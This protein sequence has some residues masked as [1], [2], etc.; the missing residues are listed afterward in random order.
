[1]QHRDNPPRDDAPD[2]Q[3]HFI[4]P[5]EFSFDSG[6]SQDQTALR[7]KS[8]NKGGNN[9]S[10]DR[11]SGSQLLQIAIAGGLVTALVGVFWVL[12][13]MVEKPTIAI[14]EPT[15][16]TGESTGAG[17]KIK[18]SPFTDA[19]IAQQRREVQKV[20]QD[21]LQL[22]DE[23][24]ERRIE[25][26]AAEEY[27]AART[28]AEEADQIYR[29]RKFQQALEQYRTTRDEFQALRDSIPERIERHLSEGT[30]ALDRGDAEAAHKAFD[31]VL[32]I[33]ED[34]PRGTEGKK[35][36]EKLPQ[37]WEHFLAGQAAFEEN[38]LDN[39]R[40][41]L[42]AALAIDAETQPAKVLLPKVLAAIIE[43]DYS[44]AMSA[45]YA[46]ISDGDFDTAKRE[47][48]KAKK[49]KPDA[50][51]PQIG[52]TQAENGIVQARIDGLFSGASEFERKEQWHKAV[53]NYQKLIKADNSLVRAITGKAR[54]E[55][56]AKLDDKLEEL[57]DDPLTLSQP[58]RNQF[59]R[60]V[61]ADARALNAQTPRLSDQIE[62]LESAITQSLIPITVLLQSD[63]STDVTIYHVGKLGH[64]SEREVALKPGRY[65]VVGTRQGYRDVRQEIVVD[66][67]L[68]APTVTIRCAEKLNSANSG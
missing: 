34:H 6:Q 68:T 49:L 67:S 19:E 30:A 8:G 32:T 4:Q 17:A 5:A 31:M 16:G 53:D 10:T 15:A 24:T 52:I 18:A 58:K 60:K 54:A 28:L 44:R 26:W 56:R 45:G 41:S 43:R 59:A 21:I 7:N 35:R 48:A 66:P 14:P 3:E 36:A 39:A 37:V 46:A 12:P 13:Q 63:A 11:K 65:T 20:L 51:D 64:F 22:Q 38:T 1:M 25:V 29:Q 55:A 23:L 42:Q 40:D 62:Q 57:L 61:L 27:F 47:F 2:D 50:S 33:S 9:R